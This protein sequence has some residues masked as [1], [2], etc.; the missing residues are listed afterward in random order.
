MAKAKEVLDAFKMNAGPGEVSLGP[1][2]YFFK[3]SEFCN[4]EVN[5]TVVHRQVALMRLIVLQVSTVRVV[6]DVGSSWSFTGLIGD[7][8]P[9]DPVPNEA[10]LVD[11]KPVSME[12]LIRT[13]VQQHVSR[14][15]ERMETLEES[16][17]LEPDGD[18]DLP[19]TRH[20]LAALD[21]AEF[22][23]RFGVSR[24]DVEHAKGFLKGKKPGAKAPTAA[25]AV[26]SAAPADSA[27]P[28][29][30]TPKAAATGV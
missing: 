27:S 23:D 22:E 13:M 29:S 17:D 2:C 4:L 26:P 9:V 25:P 20:E 3:C 19:L 24:E 11:P 30:P 28:A 21:E 6:C 10:L 16:D 1:G 12:E 7:H 8:D 14:A 18:D 5:G 15:G